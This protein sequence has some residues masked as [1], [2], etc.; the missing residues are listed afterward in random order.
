M[1]KDDTTYG[2]EINFNKTKAEINFK[3]EPN[4][5]QFAHGI[6]LLILALDNQVEGGIKNTLGGVVD[7]MENITE[8]NKE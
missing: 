4:A 5:S 8:P 3:N 2:I 6:A 7:A 1:A